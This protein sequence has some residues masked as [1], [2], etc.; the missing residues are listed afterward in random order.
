MMTTHEDDPLATL[1]RF[2]YGCFDWRVNGYHW[3]SEPDVDLLSDVTLASD[4]PFVVLAAVVECAKLGDHRQAIRLVPFFTQHEPF[5]LAR[6]ALLAFA[7]IATAADL[8]HLEQ[9]LRCE[10]NAVRTY[11]GE[12]AG[13]CG[14]LALVPTMLEAWR[15][16]NSIHDYEMIGFALSDMLEP[17]AGEIA[18]HVGIR[19]RRESQL[20]P[21]SEAARAVYE[22]VMAKK[23]ALGLDAL[24]AEPS[25]F[26]GLVMA[27][28]ARLSQLFG[29]SAFVWAGGELDMTRFVRLFLDRVKN[30]APGVGHFIGLRHRFEAWTGERCDDFFHAFAP[31]RLDMAA[32]LEDFLRTK[33]ASYVPGQRYFFGHP[34][35]TGDGA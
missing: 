6:V 9:A 23:R 33:A 12:A 16:G 22:R 11:A 10:D 19:D 25:P 27:E 7:D 28:Y 13:Y 17:S 14:A 30:P 21:K 3:A 24:P 18:G 31:Q 26:P 32:T 8:H 1:P 29:Q 35:P 2:L 15:A 5:A 20:E 34:I 4:N